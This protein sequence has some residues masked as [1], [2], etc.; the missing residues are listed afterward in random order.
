MFSTTC[1]NEAVNR[2]TVSEF[3]TERQYLKNVTPK[4]LLWYQDAF[5][6]F[7]GALD[8]EVAL[9]RRIVELRTRGVSATSVNS[10]LRCIN[11][12]LKW[13]GAGFKLPK[14][15]EEQKVIATLT[16]EQMARLIA[17]KPKG[18]NETRTHMAAL[19]IL[20]GGYRISELLELPCEGC[21]FENLVVKIRG[22]GNK[23]RLVPL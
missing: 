11:A 17:Y 2:G 18:I 13:Q 4:T 22:K 1:E 14:L 15:K 7:G 16:P 5:K 6:A 20:D 3:I 12:Y 10:W 21:D 9:K 23:Q 8:S 19:L